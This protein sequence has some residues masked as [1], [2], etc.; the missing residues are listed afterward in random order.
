[1]CTVTVIPSGAGFRLVSNRDELRLRPPC[2]APQVHTLESGAQAIWPID[3]LAG[4]TWIAVS[5]GGVAL[6]LLNGNPAH[7]VELPPKDQLRSR[8]HLIPA[9]IDAPSAVA[10]ITQLKEMDLGPYA[11]FR[12]VAVDGSVVI[13]A[14]WD[15]NALKI[16]SRALCLV[17]FVSSG[18]GDDVVAERVPLFEQWIAQHGAT[19]EA[20]DAFHRHTWPERLHQSV[21]MTRAD[22]RTVA[23]TSVDTSIE[24]VIRLCHH[25][26]LATDSDSSVHEL[27]LESSASAAREA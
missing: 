1:M 25:D 14:V 8:G 9:M 11:F 7:P 17:C 5:D 10:A 24:G 2:R 19:A 16:T 20:Q 6:T 13:D 27:T 23:V 3:Q 12:L 18:L 15:R 26:L 22:A 21:M 4:G